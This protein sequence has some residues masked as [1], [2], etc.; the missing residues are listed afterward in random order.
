M[1]CI[2]GNQLQSGETPRQDTGLCSAS[3]GGLRGDIEGTL[4]NLPVMLVC[5]ESLSVGLAL[6][7]NIY[8]KLQTQLKRM[9]MQ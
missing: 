3:V 9:N 2:P 1:K 7:P 6:R 4:G 8:N 5:E